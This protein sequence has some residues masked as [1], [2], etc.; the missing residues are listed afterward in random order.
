MERH[1]ITPDEAFAELRSQ[2]R[3]TNTTVVDV[4][5]AVVVSYPL[6]RARQVPDDQRPP[7]GP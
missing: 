6:F 2:A 7:P 4:A 3:N 5:E 1:G